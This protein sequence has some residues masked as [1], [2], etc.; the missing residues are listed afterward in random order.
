M[1]TG[2]H[3]LT[4]PNL[5]GKNRRE[6]KT[7]RPSFRSPGCYLFLNSAA[8]ISLSKGRSSGR[9]APSLTYSLFYG[10]SVG[11]P[12]EL[13]GLILSSE[14]T[15]QDLFATGY[16]ESDISDDPV[17]PPTDGEMLLQ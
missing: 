13:S 1:Q 17:T 6:R 11:E 10:L 7:P 2:V 15:C 8:R 12:E 5:G 14:S 4:L 16:F 3:T 9:D